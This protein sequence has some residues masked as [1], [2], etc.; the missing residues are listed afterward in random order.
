MSCKEYV[1]MD[2]VLKPKFIYYSVGY[3]RHGKPDAATLDIEGVDRIQPVVD[4]YCRDHLTASAFKKVMEESMAS[5]KA[6]PNKK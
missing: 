6:A 1:E 4:E 5:E 2:D 3:S